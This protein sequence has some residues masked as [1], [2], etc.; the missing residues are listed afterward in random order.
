[1]VLKELTLA[2]PQSFIF[3][4]SRLK[5]RE[6]ALEVLHRGF[7]LHDRLSLG[8][9]VVVCFTCTCVKVLNLS[10]V[11]LNFLLLHGLLFALVL[12]K[13]G[14]VFLQEAQLLLQFRVFPVELLLNLLECLPLLFELL[15]PHVSLILHALDI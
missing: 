11:A 6:L 12:V 9:A 14:V 4:V 10:L 15:L 5:I 3:V 1:M 7:E 13:A 8:V 2:L